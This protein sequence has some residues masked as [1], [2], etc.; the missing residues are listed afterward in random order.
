MSINTIST[1]AHPAIF[2][3]MIYTYQ[4][5]QHDE[6]FDQPFV[7]SL[8]SAIR[9]APFSARLLAKLESI[10]TVEDLVDLLCET[11]IIPPPP[12]FSPPIVLPR[13]VQAPILSPAVSPMMTLT[14]VLS[15]GAEFV[16]NGAGF[17]LNFPKNATPSAFEYDTLCQ[18]FFTPKSILNSEAPQWFSKPYVDIGHILTTHPA[19]PKRAVAVAVARL[20]SRLLTRINIQLDEFV[21]EI[22]VDGNKIIKYY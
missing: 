7:S 19:K 13:S 2:V 17:S 4:C 3:L 9:K 10:S 8:V 16:E 18:Y 20:A 11:H 14:D 5:V 12:T 22:R 21:M 6:P 1:T 15:L